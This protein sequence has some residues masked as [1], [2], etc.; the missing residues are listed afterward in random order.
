MRSKLILLHFR[1]TDRLVFEEKLL[2][3]VGEVLKT[4][5]S[6][7]TSFFFLLFQH[8]VIELQTTLIVRFCLNLVEN[9]VCGVKKAILDRRRHSSINYN[10]YILSLTYTFELISPF[11]AAAPS[12]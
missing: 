3:N 10:N 5:Q 9:I 4:T 8:F 6:L 2:Q 12:T 1:V 7:A 11:P